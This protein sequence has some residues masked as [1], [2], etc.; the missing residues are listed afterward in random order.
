MC[1]VILT[2]LVFTAEKFNDFKIDW[3]NK[4]VDSLKEQSVTG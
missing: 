4:I 3:K 2:T 1:M